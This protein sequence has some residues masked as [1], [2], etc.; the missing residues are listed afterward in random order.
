MF[1]GIHPSSTCHAFAFPLISS[2]N[3]GNDESAAAAL[4]AR[5]D[6]IST[7]TNA[8][9]LGPSGSLQLQLVVG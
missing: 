9:A 1:L 3:V 8:I 7:T 5:V 2:R 4:R 6:A